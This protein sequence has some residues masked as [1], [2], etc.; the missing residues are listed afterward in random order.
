MQ[1]AASIEPITLQPIGYVERQEGSDTPTSPGDDLRLRPA[2][3]IIDPEL[4]DALMGIEAGT[5]LV[6]LWYCHLGE[7]YQLQIHPRGDAERPVRGLFATR[8]PRRPNPI[9]LTSVRVLHVHGNVLD[10]IGLDALDG[11]P[12]I[13]IKPSV[14]AFDTPYTEAGEL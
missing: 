5:D 14:A 1:P 7:G 4:T 12:V 9:A 3:I 8:T 10:V 13:D 11:S 6:I 2:R